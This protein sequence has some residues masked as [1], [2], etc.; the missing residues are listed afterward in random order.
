MKFPFRTLAFM[1]G[2][3]R[4]GVMAIF[5]YVHVE[6]QAGLRLLDLMGVEID[7][8]RCKEMCQAMQTREHGRIET[9][10]LAVAI[11]A[12]YGRIFVG[13]V[14]NKA[15]LPVETM[16]QPNELTFH[17][18]ILEARS[19][20]AVHSIN[21]METPKLR[22]WLNPVERGG[23]KVNNVNAEVVTLVTLSN[24]EYLCLQS[25]CTKLLQWVAEQKQIEETQLKA[26]VERD[27]SLDQLYSFQAGVSATGNLDT[28]ARSR[29][30]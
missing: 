13:G 19:K 17:Q 26:I 12:V 15:K 16:L 9:D 27:F 25:L 22:V 23:R 2:G 3:H 5:T 28:S 8:T 21:T 1:L 20:H 11:L 10:A 4:V 29:S 6:H 7:L 24:A 14:R 30:R 18:Q